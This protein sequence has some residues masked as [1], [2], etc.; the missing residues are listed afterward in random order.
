MTD[1]SNTVFPAPK[2]L[3]GETPEDASTKG[4]TEGG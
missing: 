1:L 2:S 3:G 4:A